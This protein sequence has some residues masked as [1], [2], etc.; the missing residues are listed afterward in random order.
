MDGIAQW[1]AEPVSSVM[2]RFLRMILIAEPAP[3]FMQRCFGE[4]HEYSECFA[5]EF[6]CRLHP[7]SSQAEGLK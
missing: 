4:S 5:F 3:I 6:V 2:P 1:S 7:R